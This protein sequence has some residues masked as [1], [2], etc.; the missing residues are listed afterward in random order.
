MASSVYKIGDHVEIWSQTFGGW[1]AG[2]VSDIQDGGVKV[3][4]SG[5][6]KFVPKDQLSFVRSV[7]SPNASMQAGA[8]T[9]VKGQAV[10]IW[11]GTF[12][13]WINGSVTEV[14]GDMSVTIQYSGKQKI[15]P[16]SQQSANLRSVAESADYLSNAA[17]NPSVVTPVGP[18]HAGFAGI[19]TV[20]SCVDDMLGQT[21]LGDSTTKQF[22]ELLKKRHLLK[23][24]VAKAFAS[25]AAGN[26]T[27]D[28]SGLWL[29]TATLSKLLGLPGCVFSDL[30]T[31]YERFDFGGSGR[32]DINEC[33]KL[34]FFQIM[35]YWR[36]SLNGQMLSLPDMPFKSV[37]GAGY[38]VNKVLGQGSQG[39][40][41]LAT[42]S[43][44]REVCVKSI[45][46][47]L[48][49][50][51]AMMELQEE[52]QA[53]KRVACDRI[54]RVE[55]LFQ[56]HEFYYMVTEALQGGTFVDLKTRAMQQ[57]VATTEGWWKRVFKQCLEALAY[58]HSNALMHC[59]VKEPNLML[60]TPYLNNPD[61]VLIDFGV[62]KA[63]VTTDSF[64]CGTPGYIPPETFRTGKWYPKGDIFSLGVC[65]MQLLTDNVPEFDNPLVYP[66]DRKGI[67][68]NGCSTLQDAENVVSTREPAFYL[69]QQYLGLESLAR[70]MLDKSPERRLRAPQALSHQWFS[71]AGIASAPLQIGTRLP[72]QHLQPLKTAQLSSVN[73]LS[74]YSPN[75]VQTYPGGY[76]AAELYASRY[77]ST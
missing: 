6:F 43:Q 69:L 17:C 25:A 74:S 34:A 9:F 38:H 24:L 42:T 61:V 39:V 55:E 15:I 59:D 52:F 60:K 8:T 29:F 27:L 41:R 68:L 54:L 26:S 67:F 12:G 22:Q 11:S 3:S 2:V 53:M 51:T 36:K 64:P 19:E 4:Y 1:I 49:Q 33:Y 50:P 13:G 30:G 71:G 62:S 40:V 20:G 45:K 5:K 77:S 46:K 18:V 47:D 35:Q 73:H 56:D 57:G 16:L 63:M 48:T 70:A 32:L 28:L 72:T 65:I 31:Q 58:M 76:S 21:L 10:E 37:Q 23:D 14:A 66:A 7:A 44:G 75:F